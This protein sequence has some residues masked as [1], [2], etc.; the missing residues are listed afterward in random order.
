MKRK[1]NILLYPVS[2][3]YGLVTDIRNFLYDKKVIPAEEFAIPVISIGNITVGGTGKTPHCEYLIALLKKDFKV[4]ALSRGYRRKS[5]GFMMAVQTSTVNDI[6]DEPLQ[7]SRKFNDIPVAVDKDRVE[8]VLTILEHHPETNVIILDDAFQHRS[9]TPGYSILLTDYNNL[10]TRDYM[11][12]F[13]DLREKKVNMRRADV[14][15]ITKCPEKLTPIERR[16]IVKEI[17]KSTYQNLYFTSLLYMSPVPVFDDRN[18]IAPEDTDC[19]IVL[20]TGIANAVPLLE[21]LQKKYREIIHLAFPDHH[22]FSEKDLTDMSAAFNSLKAKKRY[23]FTT[24][25]DA[26]RLREF[27]NIAEPLKSAFYYIPIGIHF[28]NEDK[29]EFDNLIIDYVRKNHRN[30]KFS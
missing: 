11:L 27:I 26:V 7:M 9:I 21:F 6:G 22:N 16:L 24:E 28:L 2:I 3:I 14:I 12:P 23:L 8:G 30:N 13:G 1:N 25:K 17:D 19:G 29:N 15:L 5:K 10:I 4:A 18:T 20:V